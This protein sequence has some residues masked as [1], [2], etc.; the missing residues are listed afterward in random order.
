MMCKETEIE[1]SFVYS[2]Y[3][4]GD[5]RSCKKSDFHVLVF[6]ISGHVKVLD[7][8]FPEEYLCAGEILFVP[9]GRDYKT[10]ALSDSILLIHCFSNTVCKIENCILS[11]L[12]THKQICTD[13]RKPYYFS[14]LPTCEQLS[15]LLDGIGSYIS[16]EK[17]EPKLWAMKHKELMWLFTKYYSHEELQ[18]FFHPMIDEQ[19]PFKSLVLAHYRK[20]EYTDKLAEMCGYPLYTFRRIFKAEF[21]IS[22]HR[23]LTMKRAELIQ[24]RLSLHYIPFLDI[25]E[26]FNF[27]SPQQFN[28]FCKENLGDSPTALRKKALR[29]KL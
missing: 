13:T 11:F 29:K 24:Y 20:A 25:I 27:S 12:Y 26:E 8:L 16:D 9:R 3:N 19:I 17:Y 7:N 5:I 21:G 1:C 6:C 10:L 23:W 4:V 22:P 2:H 14:K 15:H 18:L 28:R